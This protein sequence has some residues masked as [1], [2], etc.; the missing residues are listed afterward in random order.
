V[1]AEQPKD[2][3]PVQVLQT[4]EI[5][6]VTRYHFSFLPELNRRQRATLTM[7]KAAT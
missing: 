4:C 1:F 7:G 2:H 3:V 5:Q 6:P